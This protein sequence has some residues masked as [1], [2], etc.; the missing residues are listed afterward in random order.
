MISYKSNAL[1]VGRG[2]PICERV[3]KKTVEYFKNNDNDV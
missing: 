1:K 2:S 3:S